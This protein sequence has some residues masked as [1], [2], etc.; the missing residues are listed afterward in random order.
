MLTNDQTFVESTDY[1]TF[2]VKK[3]YILQI[4]LLLGRLGY[5][6]IIL[7]AS[8]YAAVIHVHCRLARHVRINQ[9]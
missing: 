1:N 9:C 8:Y 3:V 7:I 4:S 2:Y 5:G 6:L